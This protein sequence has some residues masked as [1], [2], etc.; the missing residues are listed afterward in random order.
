MTRKT[1]PFEEFLAKDNFLTACKRVMAK[2]ARGWVDKKQPED[3]AGKDG[4]RLDKLIA[5]V[6]SGTYTPE[7][8]AAV[9]VPK[10]GRK[11]GYRELG[12]PT[13]ADKIVQ[14]A[15]LQVVEPLAEKLFLDTSYGYRPGK[16]ARK[17]LRRVE[18]FLGNLRLTWAVSQDIDNFFDTLDHDRLL[19]LFHDLVRGE[20]RLVDLVSLWCRMGIVQK[21][22]RWR[23]VMTGVRQGQVISPLLANLYLHD[24]DRFVQEQGWGWVR[25]ADDCAPRRRAQECVD[26]T[27]SVQPCCTGDEGWP[28]G[29]A[30]QVEASNHL[31]LLWSKAMVVSVKEKG[32]T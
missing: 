27:H 31:K 7:P 5:S 12:L 22:G 29:A 10:F 19:S 6:R 16:G 25:Y 17:A 21:D 24:L 13:V 8:V 4:R 28:L 18:H 9:R 1:T 11:G 30:I 32:E 3:Y 14:A 23:N 26:V 2:G 15:L 20:Q